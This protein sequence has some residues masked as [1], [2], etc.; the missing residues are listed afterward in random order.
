M[1][2]MMNALKCFSSPVTDKNLL[3]YFTKHVLQL[4]R[5]KKLDHNN[6]IAPISEGIIDLESI[7]EHSQRKINIM[8]FKHP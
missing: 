4:H 6:Y 5:K 1:F 8:F 3:K 7:A 2:F